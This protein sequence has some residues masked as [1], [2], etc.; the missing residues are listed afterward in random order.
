[1]L[2]SK[3]H[4]WKVAQLNGRCLISWRV[5]I[6]LPWRITGFLILNVKWALEIQLIRLISTKV[7]FILFTGSLLIKSYTT[8]RK[9]CYQWRLLDTYCNRIFF[10]FQHRILSLFLIYKS[11][12]SDLIFLYKS[13]FFNL[14]GILISYLFSCLFSDMYWLQ[15]LPVAI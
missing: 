11:N 4:K 3:H 6:C 12:T 7:I 5:M 13:P 15:S 8:V 2:T 10:S 14:I 9:K 1:M